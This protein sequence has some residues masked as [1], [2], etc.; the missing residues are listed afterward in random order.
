M[1]SL[2]KAAT[3]L[4]MD[5][6]HVRSMLDC[7]AMQGERKVVGEKEKW[8]VHPK[9][10]ES[11]LGSK[12]ILGWTSKQRTSLEGMN[13]FFDKDESA[14]NGDDPSVARHTEMQLLSEL[15]DVEDVIAEPRRN[16]LQVDLSMRIE[17]IL[18]TLTTEFAQR[19]CEERETVVIL[20]DT[21]KTKDE[22][23]AKLA[24][25]EAQLRERLACIDSSKEAEIRCLNTQIAL[26]EERLAE[27][28]KPWWTRVFA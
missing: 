15:H 19:L 26:L 6:K 2:K 8:Y 22:Q 9:E 24:D 1:V 10:I 21:V 23:I 13:Q 27:K 17:G 18:K 28:K 4:G 5:K 20:Q 14:G 16:H 25:S 11:F 7:G 3:T 12:R